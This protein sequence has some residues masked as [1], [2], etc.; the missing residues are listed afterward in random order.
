MPTQAPDAIDD[1]VLSVMEGI[2]ERGSYTDISLPY[3]NF[4]VTE[5]L[6]ENGMLPNGDVQGTTMTFRVHY[7]NNTTFRITSMYDTNN[8]GR[9][10]GLAQGT[11][12][13]SKQDVGFFYD[14]DEPIFNAPDEYRIIDHIKRLYHSAENDYYVGMESAIYNQPTGPDESPFG[15]L[16]L[17]HWLVLD[18]ALTTPSFTGGNPSG[19]TAG[20]A[21]LSSATY[22]GWDNLT[23]GFTTIDWNFVESLFSAF[24]L[25]NFEAP[26]PYPAS[27]TGKSG[28]FFKTTLDN[29]NK[30]RNLLR[31]A[32][33]NYGKDVMGFANVVLNSQEL[34]FSSYLTQTATNN[35][36]YAVNKAHL[37]F[38]SQKG[39]EGRWTKPITRPDANSVRDVFKS[40]WIQGW[41]DDRRQAGFVCAQA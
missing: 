3:Q 33:E 29:I 27:K 26:D 11:V 22:S 16:G 32:N 13:M 34:K 30:M 10:K 19:F 1:L 31:S 20:A 39:K 37:G 38:K 5:F 8:A 21:G 17:P 35:I 7:Q 9:A 2:Q 41:C 14:V 18:T 24:A 25:G 4:T 6:D 23:W 28:Y 36:F 15:I 12:K 40:S